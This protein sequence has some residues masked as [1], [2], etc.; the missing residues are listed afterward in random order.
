MV[1]CPIINTSG[2]LSSLEVPRA[3]DNRDRRTCLL[4]RKAMTHK[5][6]TAKALISKDAANYINVNLSIC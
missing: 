1:V 2:M 4:R 5:D 3:K 6:G